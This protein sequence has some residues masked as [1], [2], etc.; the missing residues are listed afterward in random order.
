M[1]TGEPAF[2]GVPIEA[3]GALVGVLCVYDD[4]PSAWTEHDVD[5]LRELAGTV[6]AELERGALASE[7]ESS[8][9]RL[10]LGFA[11]ADI[12]S[13]DWDLVTTRCTGTT[14]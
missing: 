13:F 6:A 2:L 4:Q 10:D 1:I 3:A 14:G 5:V 9:V 7:L 8:T 11:A 12:G